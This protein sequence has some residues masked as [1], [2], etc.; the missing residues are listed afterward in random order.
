MHVA[1]MVLDAAG[2]YVLP[3]GPERLPFLFTLQAAKPA[4]P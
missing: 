4:S 2:R 3:G 1:S